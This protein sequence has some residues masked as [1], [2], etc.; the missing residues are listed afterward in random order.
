MVLADIEP[1]ALERRGRG[2]ARGRRAACSPC[3]TDVSKAEQVQALADRAVAE[4]G[5]RRRRLQQRRRGAERPDRGSTRSPTGS[6]CS[7][8]NLWGVVHGIRTFVPLMLRQGGEGHV[9]NTASVARAHQQ[10]VHGRLQREQA[11]G[12]DA[13][14]DARTR[15]WRSSA[16]RCRVSVLCPGFVNT[17]ILD[18]RAQPARR[19]AEPGRRPSAIRRSRRWRAPRIAAGLPPAEVGCAVVD[20]VKHERF[21]VLT[22][23][24]FA[25]AR[26]RAHGGHPRGPQSAGGA[27]AR[28]IVGAQPCSRFRPGCWDIPEHFNIGVACTD[29]H[30]GTAAGGRAPR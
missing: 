5:A 10:P 28:L 22:H 15:S 30:L 6:G 13:L 18:S 20:A 23:P 4:F 25:H 3:P 1:D 2:A 21:Y 9:V 19:A 26:A 12:R 17:R 29:A 14:G 24:E 16:R 27:V 8:V 7:G 11:R